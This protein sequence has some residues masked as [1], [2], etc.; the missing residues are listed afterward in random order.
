MTQ[1]QGRGELRRTV[2]LHR[3]EAV[4]LQGLV[5]RFHFFP[6][7]R[8]PVRTDVGKLAAAANQ[9]ASR[10]NK[11]PSLEQIVE[12]C[13]CRVNKSV[14]ELAQRRGFKA[15]DEFAAVITANNAASRGSPVL[16]YVGPSKEKTSKIAGIALEAVLVLVLKELDMVEMDRAST[17]RSCRLSWASYVR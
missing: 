11:A 16:S 8:Y 4:K 2:S 3:H 9:A 7:R 14:A 10:Q 15:S 13:D 5:I 17:Y 12:P 6:I 1:F